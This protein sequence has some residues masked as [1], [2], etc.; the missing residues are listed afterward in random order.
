MA[1]KKI[2]LSIADPT[3]N[4][5][6]YGDWTRNYRQSTNVEDRRRK[7]ADMPDRTPRDF[8]YAEVS[9]MN[10]P[11]LSR[12][13]TGGSTGAYKNDTQTPDDYATSDIG[14]KPNQTTPSSTRKVD[15]EEAIRRTHFERN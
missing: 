4:R 12:T 11:S 15:A 8:D 6:G 7:V 14:Y 13:R 9:K 2:N 5:S 3:V 10:D 1:R